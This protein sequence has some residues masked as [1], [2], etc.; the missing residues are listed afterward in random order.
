LGTVIERVGANRFI[1]HDGKEYREGDDV[2][3][4]FHGEY[5]MRECALAY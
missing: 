3:R 1:V 5:M 2:G 4:K